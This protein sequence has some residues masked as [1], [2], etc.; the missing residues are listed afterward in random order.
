MPRHPAYGESVE[1]LQRRSPAIQP[2]AGPARF[3][4]GRD[5]HGS[6][7]VQDRQGQIGGLFATENA[8]LHFA[9]EECHDNPADVCRAPEGVVLDFATAATGIVH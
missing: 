7:I 4:V 8:A 5:S 2:P 9:R 6:W 1:P 3:L